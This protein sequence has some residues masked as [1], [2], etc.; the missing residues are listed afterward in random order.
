MPV[1]VESV[2]PLLTLLI[3]TIVFV[4][5]ISAT[6]LLFTKN[7]NTSLKSNTNSWYSS[8]ANTYWKRIVGLLGLKSN[9][10]TAAS[11]VV[12]PIMAV[13]SG[14]PG[15]SLIQVISVL[16]FGPIT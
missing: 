2:E 1:L 8:D 5:G 10:R 7:A 11:F 14:S 12:W 9:S 4:C 3:E 6:F 13:T 15:V 16:Q